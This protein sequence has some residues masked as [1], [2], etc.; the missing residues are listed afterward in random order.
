VEA[1]F[2]ETALNLALA[3]RE[4]IVLDVKPAS[5][6]SGSA[7]AGL[8]SRGRDRREVLEVTRAMAA[9]LPAGL[10]LALGARNLFRDGDR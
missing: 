9:L 1:A 8:R 4:L 2:N 5:T 7:N 6:G 10:P 3:A